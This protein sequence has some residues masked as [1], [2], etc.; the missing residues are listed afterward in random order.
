MWFKPQVSFMEE[1]T[2]K[3]KREM[4]IYIVILV[5][6]IIVIWGYFLKTEL[7]EASSKVK[8]SDTGLGGILKQFT[9]SAEKGAV[10]FNE[11]KKNLKTATSTNE[12]G[13]TAKQQ[14]Q[15]IDKLKNKLQEKTATSTP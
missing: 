14:R 6:V 12:Q 9:N 13:L 1:P 8:Q 10:L 11:W 5:L 15:L 7:R 2:D 3:Q 4:W